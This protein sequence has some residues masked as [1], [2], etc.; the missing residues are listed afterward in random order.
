MMTNVMLG[1][2]PDLFNAGAASSGVPFGCFRSPTGAIR[3]WSDQCANGTL[4]MTG[5]Q[6]GNQVRAAFPGYTGRRPRMQLWHGTGDDTLN[7]QNF[8]EETKEWT[9]VFG[10]SQCATAAK[11]NDPDL[12]YT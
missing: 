10:I 7:Y 6:W 1:S 12:L 5:E 11:E 2:Y 9:D 4:V 8:I 3:A